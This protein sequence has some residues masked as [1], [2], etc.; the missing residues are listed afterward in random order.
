M[1]YFK[2]KRLNKRRKIEFVVFLL[3]GCFF[4]LNAIV[5]CNIWQGL[6]GFVLFIECLDVLNDQATENIINNY[7][8][9]IKETNK[10][11]EKNFKIISQV[12]KSKD[13]KQLEEIVK[14]IDSFYKEEQIND[15]ESR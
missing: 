15:S 1:K 4:M 10:L 2:F 12:I 8:E 5:T 6:F 7:C 13:S 11:T 3:G 14:Q 9:Y